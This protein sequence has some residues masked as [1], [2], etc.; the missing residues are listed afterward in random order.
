MSRATRACQYLALADDGW[1]HAAGVDMVE[2]IR[3]A[4]TP[5]VLH[6]SGTD[7]AVGSVAVAMHTAPVAAAAALGVYAKRT[8]GRAAVRAVGQ[9]VLYCDHSFE[10]AA[11]V[12]RCA[13]LL[14]EGC[15]RIPEAV[16][17]AAAVLQSILPVLVATPAE[18]HT[19]QAA[20]GHRTM[21]AAASAVRLRMHRTAVRTHDV[22]VGR[23][24]P[25]GQVCVLR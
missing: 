8:A 19:R 17:Q 7:T 16:E 14:A 25:V 21:R 22:V 13:R 24:V 5:G 9:L 12:A 20:Q 23:V 3:M 4:N 18:I 11:A 6:S 1:V 15:S 2:S 10:S